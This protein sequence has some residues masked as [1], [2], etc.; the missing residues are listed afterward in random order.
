MIKDLL[1][2]NAR[3]SPPKFNIH[4]GMPNEEFK[5]AAGLVKNSGLNIAM[6]IVYISVSLVSVFIP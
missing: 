2:S 6:V 3:A 1:D 4:V 5:E